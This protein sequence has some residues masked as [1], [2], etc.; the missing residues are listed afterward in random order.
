MQSTSIQDFPP[1]SKRRLE[2]QNQHN[3]QYQQLQ[4]LQQLQQQQQQDSGY[5]IQEPPFK[6]HRPGVAANLLYKVV[7]FAAYTSAFATDAI[8]TLTGSHS[9]RKNYNYDDETLQIDD[10]DENDY[11]HNN[12]LD[13]KDVSTWGENVENVEDEEPPPPYDNSWYMVCSFIYYIYVFIIIYY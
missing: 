2:L 8:N 5:F 11:D 13:K 4:Q 7:E 10:D 6:K 12:K 9:T 3:L 1:N